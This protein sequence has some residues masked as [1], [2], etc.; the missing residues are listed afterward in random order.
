MCLNMSLVTI[1]GNDDDNLIM[2]MM[3]TIM[4]NT[5]IF[6]VK[7]LVAHWAELLASSL[8]VLESTCS[9]NIVTK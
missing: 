5:Q 9:V 4:I 2:I 6:L 3:I 8:F 1:G 7:Q